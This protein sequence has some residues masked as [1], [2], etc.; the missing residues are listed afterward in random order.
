[1]KK[2]ISIAV[3]L[4]LVVAAVLVMSSCISADTKSVT[5]VKEISSDGLVNTY[6]IVYSD[7]S[8]TEFTIEADGTEAVTVDDLYSRYCDEYGDMEYADFLKMYFT[9]TVQDSDAS[10][11]E[12]DNDSSGT[13]SGDSTLSAVNSCLRSS[14]VIYSQFVERSSSSIFPFMGSGQNRSLSISTGSGVI[15]SMDEDYTYIITNYHVVYN[16][17]AVDTQID[18]ISDHI[19]FYLYGSVGT[20]VA[21]EEDADKDGIEDYDY[22]DYAIY[23]DYIGGSVVTDI[24]VLRASTEDVLAINEDAAPVVFAD[25][26]SVGQRVF[27]IGNPDDRGIS[28]TEGVVSVDNE[29]I[30]LS[31]DGTAR[32]YRS[33]RI[34]N[35][36]YAGSSGG[37]LFNEQG[38][39]V[40]ITNAGNESEENINYAI[41]LEIVRNSVENVMYYYENEED[42]AHEMYKISL[43]VTV[44][45]ENSRFDY[46][47][48]TGSG[49]IIE[50]ITVVSTESGSIARKTEVETGDIIKGIIIN[51]SVV[52]FDRQYDIADILL[53]IRENDVLSFLVE[54]DGESVVTDSYTITA[55]DL[56]VVA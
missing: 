49:K 11:E 7:G 6:Q 21:T 13:V 38:E 47:E 52:T 17:N 3:T 45:S 35:A 40:G 25:D 24:A 19:V 54:R 46:D 42:Y 27:A 9:D 8:T 14:L 16:E 56:A 23:C 53:T 31:I 15:Y 5:S 20:P 28:V 30:A 44:Y 1:M 55:N 2:Y 10:G 4:L 12:T 48:L 33:I 34:D 32:R 41:P 29:Y 51:G 43:G 22:G 50:N 26:Y 36:I 37:G 39:L 18:G